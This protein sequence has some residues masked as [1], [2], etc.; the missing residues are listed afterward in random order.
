MKP[1]RLLTLSAALS[2]LPLASHTVLAQSPASPSVSQGA[3]VTYTI[4]TVGV[5]PQRFRVTLAIVDPKNPDWIISEFASGVEKTVTAENHGR[6]TEY[7]NGLDENYMPVPVGNYAVKGIYMPSSTWKIDG[8]PHTVMAR[9]AG[10][11]VSWAP[12]LDQD[13]QPIPV[14]GD[15]VDS[16]FTDVA[17]GPNGIA[18]FYYQYLENAQN[19]YMCD[20]NKPITNGQ[21]LRSF[22]SG[23]AA[24]GPCTTTDG[25]SVWSFSADGGPKF[26]YRAD[27]KPFGTGAGAGRRNV[28]NPDGWVTGMACLR[29]DAASKTYVYIAERGMIAK[30]KSGHETTDEFANKLV[31]LDGT[32]AKELG[33][34]PIF[35]PQSA[36]ARNGKIYVLH[37]TEA[38]GYEVS[39]SAIVAG[40][41]QAPWQTVLAVPANVMPSDCVV[42]SQGNVYLS[43]TAKNKVFKYSPSGQLVLTIGKLPVQASGHY[44]PLSLMEPAKMALWTDT[45]G[46]ERLIVVEMAGPNRIGEWGTDGSLIREWMPAQTKANNGYAVDPK[47][48]AEV[49]LPG[50]HNWLDRY[51]IDYAT[52]K[53][54]VD[55]VYPDVDGNLP[56]I[57]D[58]N[59]HRY[60]AFQ[61]QARDFPREI[62]NYRIY[63]LD[64]DRFVKAAG[65]IAERAGNANKAYVWHD[66]K[67]DGSITPGQ[68]RATELDLTNGA[69]GSYFGETVTD[70]LSWVVVD[71]RG[72]RVVA[73][74][75]KSFDAFGN[76]VYDP[77]GWKTLWTDP[78]FAAKAAGKADAIH[79]GNEVGTGYD[80]AWTHANS[81]GAG[82]YYFIN[83]SGP[84]FSANF[85]GQMK[86]MHF[87]PN[88]AGVQTLKWRVGR[89]ALGK[90]ASPGEIYA[91]LFVDKPINH[92]VGVVD[93]SR[94]GYHLFTEDGL[95]I[96]TVLPDTKVV[97]PSTVGTYLPPGEFFAGGTYVGPAG[98]VYLKFGKAEPIIYALDGWSA[99]VANP[100]HRL[101]DLPATVKLTLADIASPP[102][103]ALT[104]RGGAAAAKL[105]R[106]TPSTGGMPAMD[107]SMTGWEGADP[108]TFQV[109]T[110][111]TVEARLQYDHDNLYVRWHARLGRPFEARVMAPADH[112]FTHDREADTLSLYLQGDPNAPAPVDGSGRPGDLRLVFGL[113]NDGSLV[114]STILGLYK[115]WRGPGASPLT[116]RTPVGAAS[117]ENV[118]SIKANALW[119]APDADGKG[120]VIAA[121]L[122]KAALAPLPALDPATKTT[123]DL[124]ATF[125]GHNKF[126]WSNSD[127]SANSET[128]DQPSEARL[129]PGAWSRLEFAPVSDLAV[130][131]W[132]VIGPF[133]GEYLATSDYDKD[134][135]AN[136]KLITTGEYPPQQD[137]DLSAVYTGD[138]TTTRKGAHKASWH[139]ATSPDGIFDLGEQLRWKGW[140]EEGIAYMATWIYSPQPCT[141]T[142]TPVDGHGWHS[143]H[144]RLN[145]APIPSLASNGTQHGIAPGQ[146]VTLRTGWNSL[147][148]RYE[149]LYGDMSYGMHIGG[150][151]ADLWKLRLSPVPPAPGQ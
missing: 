20:L 81:D 61:Q 128:Y 106:V 140:Q 22:A 31:T 124:E 17:V 126:W 129:Y 143:V 108:I 107:G 44:D 93:N 62:R 3:A 40:I 82:G 21:L 30:G 92:I 70:D 111:Q 99:T 116:Y 16:P 109:G 136:L 133:G 150:N 96:D 64:G 6:L 131:S 5:L 19:N 146:P 91:G 7:W 59:G 65:I 101:T 134:R 118:A 4:P 43:D 15:P 85:G 2:C 26:V 87:V 79:G 48:P 58:L 105:A 50:Q 35:K 103:I 88:A 148:I 90:V 104:M 12:R 135:N 32:N 49:Y 147:L 142:L 74:S 144:A 112:M 76:P 53:W 141:V 36:S 139:L 11:G 42:D 47:D 145:N 151:E 125:G 119:G 114:K 78:I 113:F 10:M 51:R 55:A 75:P 28:Y 41:P 63:R 132:Q 27:Q 122:P 110:T 86:L 9:Y 71:Q 57:V 117:F 72:S 1:T 83:R 14:T 69:F 68:M 38:G 89:T 123:V 39:A 67:G 102:A 120:F 34:L 56:K 130:R 8:Q 54:T 52:G 37:Q 95:Y 73:L 66:I 13:T 24:G 46:K 127:G 149:F 97:N 138:I 23:S 18:N 94:A 77:A 84:N 115:T 29:D 121:A 25:D 100:V 45:A 60:L 80:S 137:V 33:S 98:Q